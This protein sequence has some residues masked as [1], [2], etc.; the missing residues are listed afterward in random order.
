MNTSELNLDICYSSVHEKD[1]YQC[2][3][4]FAMG[5]N[6]IN[7]ESCMR[8]QCHVMS[9]H[10]EGE[11]TIG[12]EQMRILLQSCGIL[13]LVWCLEEFGAQR[14]IFG[15]NGSKVRYSIDMM[16]RKNW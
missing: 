2:C 12:N 6:V 16:N 14:N 1:I 8:K 7:M 3:E 15:P 4:F 5:K 13:L 10:D 11:L 9:I